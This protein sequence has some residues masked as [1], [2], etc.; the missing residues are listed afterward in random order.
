MAAPKKAKMGSENQLERQSDWVL[1]QAVVRATVQLSPE[2]FG[3]SGK[4]RARVS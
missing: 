4:I 1:A 2:R 3:E